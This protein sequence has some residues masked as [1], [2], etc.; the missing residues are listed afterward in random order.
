MPQTRPNV[1]AAELSKFD[2]LAHRWWDRQGEFKPLHDINPIRLD[3]IDQRTRI[4]GK[5]V[6]DVGCGGGI[7]TEDI[8]RRGARAMG[9]DLAEMP[10]AAARLHMQQSGIEIDYRNITAEDLAATH[11]N[12]FDV[13]TCM[14]TLEHVP[15]P[16]AMVAACAH[17]AK[18]GGH[19]FFSTINRNVK[20][21]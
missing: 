6:L 11:A 7:L 15:D 8:A 5:Q 12:S 16:A 19:L 2:S 13:I 14:E 10:L 1:D 20:S 3:Y 17:L 9:I 21:F 4:T 18:P